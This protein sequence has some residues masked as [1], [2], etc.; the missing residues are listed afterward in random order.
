MTK[1]LLLIQAIRSNKVVV[2]DRV[3]VKTRT[4]QCDST[5]RYFYKD[6]VIVW[7][8]VTCINPF[9]SAIWEDEQEQVLYLDTSARCYKSLNSNGVIYHSNVSD[10]CP[11][12]WTLPKNGP[13]IREINEQ[14]SRYLRQF[15]KPEINWIKEGF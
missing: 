11:V 7:G 10:H 12:Y 3:Y 6:N 14:R 9:F 15:E 8:Y 13:P 5:G 2:G 1:D 4:L